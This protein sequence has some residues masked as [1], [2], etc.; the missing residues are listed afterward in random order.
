M[1]DDP[2]N[3]ELARR[4]DDIHRMLAGVVG[5]PEYAADKRAV[6]FRLAELERDLAEERRE[7]AAA[8]ETERAARDAAVRAVGKRLD[9]QAKADGESRGR[10][11]DRLW[12]GAL[13]AVVALL[14]VLVTLWISHHGGH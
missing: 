11:H 7:R 12:T 8:I 13:P 1:P 9:D 14:G 5:H 2:S 6:D 10:W 3:W 4:L